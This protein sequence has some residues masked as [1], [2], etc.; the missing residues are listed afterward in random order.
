[1]F[2]SQAERVRHS[3]DANESKGPL[4]WFW[5]AAGSCPTKLENRL[6]TGF[7][8]N[9]VAGTCTVKL[10]ATRRSL[11]FSGAAVSIDG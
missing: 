1:M 5:G 10:L 11:L 9:S 3:L 8:M 7:T 6:C 4:A 2:R